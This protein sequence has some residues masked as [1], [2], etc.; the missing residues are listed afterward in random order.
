MWGVYV[1][2]EHYKRRDGDKGWRRIGYA[3]T[4]P[5]AIDDAFESIERAK[6]QTVLDPD[7][8]LHY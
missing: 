6:A 4:L 8:D 1:H 7:F 3:A 5:G 2:P